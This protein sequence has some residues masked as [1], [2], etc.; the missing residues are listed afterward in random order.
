MPLPHRA[1]LFERTERKIRPQSGE[2]ANR[3]GIY[4]ALAG[5]GKIQYVQMEVLEASIKRRKSSARFFL[6]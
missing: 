1:K 3:K 5:A 2:F 6:R 4:P